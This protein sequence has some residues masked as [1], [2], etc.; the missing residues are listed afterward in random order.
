MLICFARLKIISEL[1]AGER[2]NSN[3]S[4]LV[5]PFN[6]TKVFSSDFMPKKRFNF[7]SISVSFLMCRLSSAGRASHS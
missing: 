3:F 6:L 2:I 1:I 7:V 4:D 5:Y